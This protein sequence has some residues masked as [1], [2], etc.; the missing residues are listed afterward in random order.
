MR[1]GIMGGTLDPVHN[2]HIQVAKAALDQLGL[3]SVMLLPAGDPPHKSNPISKQ[4]RLEMVRLAAGE[5]KGL[6]PSDI[7][8]NRKGTTYTVDTLRQLHRENPSVEWYYLIGADTLDV[9]DTWRSFKEVAKLCIFAVTGRADADASRAKA[10]ALQDEY[11]AQ[12]VLLNFSGPDIS[13]SEVRK[14]VAEG[15]EI[16]TIVPTSVCK[17]IKDHGLYISNRSKDEILEHLRKNLK[18]ARMKHTM[19]VAETAVRLAERFGIDPVRAEFA[20][21]LHDCAKYMPLE[22]MQSLVKKYIPDTDELELEAV[23]VLHAPAGAVYAAQEFGIRDPEILSA[24]RK[25]TLGDVSMSPLEALIYTAD[26]IEP[27][28]EDFPGLAEARQLAETDIYRAMCKCAQLTNE[29]VKSQ[30]RRPHPRSL[31]MLEA[32]YHS[33]KEEKQ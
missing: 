31:A 21:L 27:G 29:H 19:G 28:R 22:E 4:D 1:V 3:D 10:K 18:P 2:G 24:I 26:F 30:G 32:F 25:H 5:V 33:I 17:Y 23:S 6:F 9:L 11:G 8:I 15:L 20:A 13:S 7:E 12:F 14:R 16:D